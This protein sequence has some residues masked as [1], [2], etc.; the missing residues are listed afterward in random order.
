VNAPAGEVRGLSRPEPSDAAVRVALVNDY[1]LVLQGL[2]GML[3]PFADRV[4][5]TE[6]DTA[7]N[8]EHAVEI[9]LFDTYGHPWGG[10]DRVHSLARDP[11]VG[12]VVVYTWQ[13]PPGQLEVVLTAGARGVLA[14]SI[15]AETLA[16][17]LVA[18]SRGETIVSPVFDRPHEH[19]WPGHDFGL[20]L[21]ESEVAAL[22][23]RGLSNREIAAALFIS[24][25]T[26]KSHLK[27][28]FR[29][30]GVGTRARAVARI[31]EDSG[32]RQTSHAR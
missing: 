32:F 23:A 15:P 29:K 17:A 27:S 13:L 31:K 19:A 24:E 21:R 12:A 10:V 28:V 18:I 4:L 6:L 26:V 7:A 11:R 25:H 30:T 9:A 8:P 22:L 16:D 2:E 14:K 5:V 20:T 3:R 1:E